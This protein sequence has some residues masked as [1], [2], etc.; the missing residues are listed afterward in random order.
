[1]MLNPVCLNYQ[2]AEDDKA[3][4]IEECSRRIEVILSIAWNFGQ[5]EATCIWC[6]SLTINILWSSLNKCE[7]GSALVNIGSCVTH[8][9]VQD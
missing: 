8:C 1:M 7:L 3:G 9:T 2:P 5:P 6:G 4:D